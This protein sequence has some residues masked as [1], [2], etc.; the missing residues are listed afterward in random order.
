MNIAHRIR[1]VSKRIPDK[2]SVVLGRDNSSYT[3][4]EFEERS[5]Q[6]ANRFVKLGLRPGMLDVLDR[7]VEFVLVVLANPAVFR[8]AVGEHSQ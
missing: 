6:L 5:N 3:F 2:R 4:R 1:E 7:E 8:A